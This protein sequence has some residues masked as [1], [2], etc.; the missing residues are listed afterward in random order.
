MTYYE[1]KFERERKPDPTNWI[2][3]STSR[4]RVKLVR[5]PD[6]RH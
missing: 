5:L 1:A 6:V 4:G 3:L 2:I